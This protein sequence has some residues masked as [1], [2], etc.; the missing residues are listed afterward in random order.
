[1]AEVKGQRSTTHGLTT[2][3]SATQGSTA[4]VKANPLILKIQKAL[5][6]D[7]NQHIDT[8]ES[9]VTDEN[10]PIKIAAA[11]VKRTFSKRLKLLCS[12]IR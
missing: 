8:V 5:Q 1:M 11:L 9:L 3:G 12:L 4:Q 7:L 6:Q 2:Q 10:T